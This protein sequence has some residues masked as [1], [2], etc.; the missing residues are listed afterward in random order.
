MRSPLTQ[1]EGADLL[2][3]PVG[4]SIPLLVTGHSRQ[5]PGWIA[6]HADGW[7]Y[8][9]RHPQMQER[10]VQDWRTLT[11]QYA[12]GIFKP[13]AQSLYVDLAENPREPAMP[14]HLGYRL[15]REPLIDLLLML[16]AIGVNHIAFNF[17]YGSRPADEV[18]EEI[19]QEVL[20]YVGD[21]Q[22]ASS[23]SLK[24]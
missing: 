8:Y 13:Y 4:N 14:I 11:A 6:E 10:I 1:L 24:P 5:S 2:P 9:P 22:A 17:K 15:G 18:L 23:L 21:R 3:K 19:G 16:K 7:L 20:P 12:P